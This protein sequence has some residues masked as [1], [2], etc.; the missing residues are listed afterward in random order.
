M[1]ARLEAV[2]EI[3][4]KGGTLCHTQSTFYP[5]MAHGNIMPAWCQVESQGGMSCV[6]R[7][8]VALS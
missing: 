2:R 4:L 6:I 3:C 1:R 5:S 8:A 7:H